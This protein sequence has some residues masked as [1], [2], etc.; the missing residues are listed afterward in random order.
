MSPVRS[1]LQAGIRSDKFDALK[2]QNREETIP[3]KLELFQTF[4]SI[5][6]HLLNNDP[7][8]ANSTI[9]YFSFIFK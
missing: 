8:S 2:Q 4:F 6:S 3:F 1:I 9:G 5:V 7:S